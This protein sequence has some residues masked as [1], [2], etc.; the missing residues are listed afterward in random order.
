MIYLIIEY[1]HVLLTIEWLYFEDEGKT[2]KGDEP[3]ESAFLRAITHFQ[4]RWSK[5]LKKEKERSSNNKWKLEYIYMK[6]IT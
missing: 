5:L 4:S 2:L 6:T 3:V 1:S